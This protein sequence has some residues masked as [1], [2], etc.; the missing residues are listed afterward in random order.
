[1]KVET[2]KNRLFLSLNFG[3]FMIQIRQGKSKKMIEAGSVKVDKQQFFLG[4]SK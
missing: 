3:D 1:M 4:R 2:Q